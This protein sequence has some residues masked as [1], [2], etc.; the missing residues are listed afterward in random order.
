M[1]E[2]ISTNFKGFIDNFYEEKGNLRISGWL[3]TNHNREDVIYFADIGHNVAF[4]NFNERPDVAKHYGTD[5]ENYLK[6]N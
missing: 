2:T 5:N 1:H 3:V 4:Y 6:W